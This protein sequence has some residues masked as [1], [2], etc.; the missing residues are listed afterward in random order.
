MSNDKPNLTICIPSK[1]EMSSFCV[2][3]YLNTLGSEELKKNYNLNH[4]LTI[5]QSDLPKARSEHVTK[6]YKNSKKGD[7]FLFIDADQTFKNEDILRSLSLIE[8]YD[9]VCGAY[10]KND[11]TMTVQPKDIIDFYQRKEGE[12]FYGSTGFMMF[13]Y[14]TLKT[15]VEKRYPSTIRISNTE[16][17]YPFFYERVVVDSEVRDE[18]VWLSEDYS[19]CYTVR[20]LGGTVYGYISPTIG[21]VISTEKFVMVPE[22]T[23]WPE[24]S[25]AIYCGRTS[26]AWS[27][28]SLEKGIGGSE[29]AVIKLSKLWSRLGYSVTVFCNCTNTGMY[30]NVNYSSYSNFKITDKFDILIIWRSLE[31]L[32]LA[33][34]KARKIFLD[35]HDVIYPEQMT[36]RILENVDLFFVKSLYHKRLLTNSA[37]TIPEN[38]IRVIPNGGVPN[39]GVPNGG[40][41]VNPLPEKDL[42]YLIYSSSYDR[43]LAYILKWAFPKIKKECPNAY[44]KVFYGWDCYDAIKPKNRE[45]LLY[46][47]IIEKLMQQDGVIHCG[48]VSQEELLKEKEKANIHLY[49]GDFQEICCISTRESA[50]VGCIPVVS[51][52]AEVFREQDYTIK[53]EGDPRSKEMQEKTADVVIDLLMNEEKTEEIRKNLRVPSDQ[54][55]ENTAEKWVKEF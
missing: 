33:K 42:N 26:E 28:K 22:I 16:Y 45:T 39:G 13:S 40:V 47:N 29:T 4:M 7:V 5:G 53:V 20:E 2:G 50:S 44:L 46:K 49:T 31:F 10:A 21:H 25:I 1:T 30:D 9:V 23:T 48:R 34:F 38:K 41:R 19:F 27:P 11:G 32:D 18:E 8:K 55:W 36:K 15:I 51:D 17:S 52:F 14:D 43:G 35:L 12:L 6:W 3:S 24:R 54:T 37:V